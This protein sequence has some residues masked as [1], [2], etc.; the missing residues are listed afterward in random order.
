MNSRQFNNGNLQYTTYHTEEKNAQ[1]IY[2][3]GLIN[4][5]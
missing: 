3:N 1:N 5:P 4:D 2:R